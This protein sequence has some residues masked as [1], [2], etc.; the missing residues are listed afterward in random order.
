MKNRTKEWIIH[1]QDD[2]N[3]SI[4][5]LKEK[6]S[7]RGVIF[8]CLRAIEKYFK[9]F[10]IE[11]DVRFQKTHDLESLY[12]EVKKIKEFDLSLSTMTEI[13]N[14]YS[15]TIYPGDLYPPTEDEAREFYKFALQVQ[16]KILMEL[17]PSR[18]L[19]DSYIVQT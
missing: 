7:I 10:L 5:L 3:I 13:Y 15:D 19:K 12:N 11:H 4:T 1:A 8:H 17:D 2:I 14:R 9:A 6:I 16:K 18:E